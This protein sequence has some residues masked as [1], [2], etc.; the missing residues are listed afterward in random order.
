MYRWMAAKPH[1][2]PWPA[3]N[4]AV[5]ALFRIAVIITMAKTRHAKA[6]KMR[7]NEELNPGLPRD[8]QEYC[9]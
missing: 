4:A 3:T 8:R 5:A 9:C 7:R 1:W 2:A 6:K